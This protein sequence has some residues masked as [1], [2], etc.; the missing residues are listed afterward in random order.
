MAASSP[1]LSVPPSP[2][3][4]STETRP[5]EEMEASVWVVT[6]TTPIRSPFSSITVQARSARRRLGRQ[7]LRRGEVGG[8]WSA[9][10]AASRSASVNNGAREGSALKSRIGGEIGELRAEP[11]DGPAARRHVDRAGDDLRPEVE[12]MV[13]EDARLHADGVQD[14]DVEA[15]R[16]GA[17]RGEGLD[18]H[19]EQRR[20]RT[21]AARGRRR[22]RLRRDEG[23]R[24]VVVAGG[25]GDAVRHLLLERIHHGG[26]VRRAVS[27]AVAAS[28]SAAWRIC[29]V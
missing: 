13:A 1:V 23:A 9:K 25:E 19:A 11:G 18:R 2:A 5:G 15:R 17:E 6:A 24:Q 21:A 26:E 14:G 7:R 10:L 8:G 22:I 12:L 3:G 20:R 4:S 16:R 28:K 27:A 29:R